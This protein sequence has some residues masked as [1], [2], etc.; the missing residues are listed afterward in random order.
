MDKE[1]YAIGN[2]NPFSFLNKSPNP[3]NKLLVDASEPK[4]PYYEESKY[5]E[6]PEPAPIISETK[7][8]KKA[9]VKIQNLVT[10]NLNRYYLIAGGFKSKARAAALEAKLLREGNNA[11]VIAPT[12]E[13]DI[14]RVS[15]ADFDTYQDAKNN[16]G[17]FAEIYGSE[18]WIF[19]Y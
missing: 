6:E 16:K 8:A 12:D 19:N 13:T 15:V 1:T 7:K 10:D 11:K 9:E 3:E 18:I 4:E 5:Y 2:F 17:S 14:Y